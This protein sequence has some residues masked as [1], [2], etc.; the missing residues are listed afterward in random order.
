[1]TIGLRLMH[2]LVF[3]LQ[4]Q[5]LI[6]RFL[7]TLFQMPINIMFIFLSPLQMAL[8]IWWIEQQT[9]QPGL[10]HIRLELFNGFLKY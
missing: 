3:G 7:G 5:D 10:W 9:P 1:M 4:F 6:L 2:R 8:G